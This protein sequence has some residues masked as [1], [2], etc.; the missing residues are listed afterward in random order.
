M[1]AIFGETLSFTQAAGDPIQLVV[2]GDDMFAR[3]ETLD[4][5]T[6]VYDEEIGR[7]CYAE[8]TEHGMASSA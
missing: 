5:Y 3:Y 6:V 4:G 2:F 1:S 8:T 7:F